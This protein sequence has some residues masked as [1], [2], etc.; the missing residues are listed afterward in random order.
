LPTIDFAGRTIQWEEE[1]TGPTIVLLPPGASTA[2]VWR[3]VTEHLAGR[4]RTVAVNVAGYG[5]TTRWQGERPI[6][7]ADEAAAAAAVIAAQGEPVHL[8]GHSFGGTIALMVVLGG[9]AVARTLTLIEPSPYEMLAQA[10]EPELH[11]QIAAVNGAFIEAIRAGDHEAAFARYV[12]YY[13]NGPGSWQAL[14]EKARSRF[15]AVA[16]IVANGL[17]AVHADRTPIAALDGLAVPALLIRGAGTSPIHARLAEI[18]AE[19]IPGARLET[20]AGAAHMLTMS[21]PG[22]VARLIGDFI[23]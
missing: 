9:Y 7:L 18:V 20:I 23:G 21:H 17:A 6:A 12:D 3:G 10:G 4:Y 19:R 5:G 22:E 11:R 14:S 1:G 15:L 13:T 16:D 8:V 2:G